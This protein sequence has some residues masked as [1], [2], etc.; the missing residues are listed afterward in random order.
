MTRSHANSPPFNAG[1]TGRQ[2]DNIVNKSNDWNTNRNLREGAYINN[3]AA[4]ARERRRIHCHSAPSHTQSE[5]KILSWRWGKKSS[6]PFSLAV[7]L[8]LCFNPVSR[9]TAERLV[10]LTRSLLRSN[11]L[12]K[13]LVER[14]AFTRKLD[15]SSCSVR[16]WHLLFLNTIAYYFTSLSPGDGGSPPFHERKEK[17][18]PDHCVVMSQETVSAA[19]CVISPNLTKLHFALLKKLLTGVMTIGQWALSG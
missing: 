11:S 17:A 18:F 5:L 7:S 3:Y 15:N 8:A 19:Y 1:I 4:S 10:Q 14:A 9:S 6:F 12:R 2:L 16:L 13:S